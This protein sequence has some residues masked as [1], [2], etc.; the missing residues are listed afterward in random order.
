MPPGPADEPSPASLGLTG[1]WVPVPLRV[2]V[3]LEHGGRW[4][5]LRAGEREWLWHHPS[6][7][8]AA[9]RRAVRPG[10]AFVDAGGGEECLPTVGGEPDHG[11]LWTRPWAGTAADA[12]ASADGLRLR[13]E[14]STDGGVVRVRY[15]ASGEPGRPLVHALHLLLDTSCA[16]RLEMPGGPEPRVCEVRDEAGAEPT[17]TAQTRTAV[18]PPRVGASTADVLGPDDGTAT[19]VVVRD[20]AAAVVVDG[21]RAL[22]LRWSAPA[23]PGAPAPPTS[24]L[25]WRNLGGWPA[26]APYRST[27][28][29]PLLGATTHLHGAAEGSAA[30]LG[31][32]GSLVWGVVLRAHR[33]IVQA[34]PLEPPFPGSRATS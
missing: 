20:T 27:G 24:L 18:W 9:Q 19:V 3:D 26:G 5:S 28:V 8:V 17:R 31:P 23:P 22:E 34:T 4:T 16:A 29:E 14:L 12:T 21:D 32:D 33:R 13:R 6:P 10:A 1:A 2:G 25:L 30:R 11:A 7:A 15:T